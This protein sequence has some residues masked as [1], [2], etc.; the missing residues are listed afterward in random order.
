MT[1]QNPVKGS[2]FPSPLYVTKD[3][4]SGVILQ[5]VSYNL[6]TVPVDNAT[7]ITLK[8]TYN[9]SFLFGQM[10]ILLGKIDKQKIDIRMF[11]A[12]K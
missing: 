2:G 4:H 11:Y 5:L 3:R 1:D 10:Q 6:S 7:H 9:A 12:N 8:P